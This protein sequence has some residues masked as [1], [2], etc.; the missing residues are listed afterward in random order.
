M[1]NENI[2]FFDICGDIECMLINILIFVLEIL[3]YFYL[4]Y[5]I[6]Y[7]IFVLNEI[8]ECLF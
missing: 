4:E 6:D 7:I 3:V 8:I 1:F 2:I 5:I